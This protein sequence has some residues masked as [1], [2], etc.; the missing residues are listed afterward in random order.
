MGGTDKNIDFEPCKKIYSKASKIVLLSGSGTEK[1]I[2]ILREEGLEWQ[3][4]FDDL[5][6]AVA[7]ADEIAE[8]G[9]AVLLSPGCASFGM[10]LHE[11]DRG[12][13]FKQAVRA[14]LGL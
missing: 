2:P 1:L 11:F 6:A 5:E 13:K 4:P 9:N 7:R 3:G 8:P 14:R 12:K 10:F